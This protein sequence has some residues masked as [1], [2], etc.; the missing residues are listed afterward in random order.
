GPA[1]SISTIKMLGASFGSLCGSTRFLWNESCIE[2]PAVDAEGV[3]GNGRISCAS[4]G[5]D[6][7]TATAKHTAEVIVSGL[8]VALAVL[9]NSDRVFLP[10]DFRGQGRDLCRR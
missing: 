2:S 5:E 6:A 4:A 3:G 9:M 8:I 10:A 7:V 1:S